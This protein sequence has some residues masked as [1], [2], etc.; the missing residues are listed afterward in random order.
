ML[1]GSVDDFEDDYDDDLDT[2]GDAVND[3][4]F[5]TNKNTIDTLNCY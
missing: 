4:I 3:N 2:V 1:A 5:F